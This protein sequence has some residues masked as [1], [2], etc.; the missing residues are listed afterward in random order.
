MDTKSLVNG[1]YGLNVTLIR[2]TEVP[3]V[4]EGLYGRGAEFS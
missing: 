2:T 1:S 4:L 3:G